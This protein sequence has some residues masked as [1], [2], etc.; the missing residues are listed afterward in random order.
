MPT[1]ISTV[2]PPSPPPDERELADVRFGRG[3]TLAGS[4]GAVVFVLATVAGV[5]GDLS[6]SGYLVSALISMGLVAVALGVGHF[7]SPSAV[8]RRAMLLRRRS[9]PRW[10]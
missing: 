1:S 9:A 4:A 10:E 2:S 5:R 8:A 7:K 6:A 3:V